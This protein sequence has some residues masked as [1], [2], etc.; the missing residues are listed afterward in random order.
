MTDSIN[1]KLADDAQGRR[2]AT[3]PKAGTITRPARTPR[4][5]A[6]LPAEIDGV[7]I[8]PFEMPEPVIHSFKRSQLG[9]MSPEQYAQNQ[10]AIAFAQQHNLIEDD[11]TPREVLEAADKAHAESANRMLSAIRKRDT[12][13]AAKD[14]YKKYEDAKYTYDR[15]YK[16]DP[17]SAA[18]FGAEKVMRDLEQNWQTAEQ[19][20]KDA[21]AEN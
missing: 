14:I 13:A 11:V 1:T 8:V 2:E 4:S 21:A 20:A 9:R 10:E 17:S 15:E 6:D 16:A 19:A 7:K 18:T 3:M 5:A 12:R